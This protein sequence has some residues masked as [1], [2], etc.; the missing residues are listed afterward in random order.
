[1]KREHVLT[2]LF[3]VI[4]AF[5]IYLFYEIIIPFFVPICWAAVFAI[6]FSP[7]YEKILG[8]LRTKGGSALI[9]CFLIVLLI[10]GPVT[11]L[12]VALVEEAVEAVSSVNEMYKNGKLEDMLQIDVP[13]LTTMKA[14]LAE[15]YDISKINL[16]EMVR[17]A[18]NRVTGVVVD[19]TTWLITN[20]TKA[21]FFFF[22]M[23]F[24]MYYFF[25]EGSRIVAKVKR[26]IPLP[27]EQVNV[28][29]THLRDVIL[30]TMY[31]SIVV[32]LIQGTLGGILFFAVGISS[33]VFWGAIMA[34][35][36]VIPFL[37]A[38][39]IYV[40]AGIILVIS[41]FYIKGFIVIL[42]G[43][44]VIS[45]IDNVIRPYLISGKAA[46]HP[47]LLFFCIMGGIYLFG[48]LGVVL[49]PMIGAIFM[50]LLKTFEFSLHPETGTTA[51]TDL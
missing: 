1:M 19:Q 25:K 24:T 8:R 32:A 14:K 45:Q 6:L 12:F 46:M 9:V 41:G 3:F 34:F 23:I 31:G 17:D 7:L 15:Y 44:F 38:F 49:G 4:S 16:D 35:L 5:F 42:A 47:L 39:L 48:L 22:L 13:L 33:P 2:V 27:A 51:P 18:M 30:A 20:G 28:T 21:V 11:Y 50:T 26:L 36:S 10:I 29:F 43:V 37:G 40:P